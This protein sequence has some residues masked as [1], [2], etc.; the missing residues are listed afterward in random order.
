MRFQSLTEFTRWFPSL[1]WS[2]VVAAA[3]LL[4]LNQIRA[5]EAPDA[6]PATKVIT[7]IVEFW[8]L[9]EADRA[10]SHPFRIECDVTHYDAA[11]KNLW[12]EDATQGGYVSVGNRTLPIK[13]GQ[14]IIV[15]GTF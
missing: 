6:L 9:S 13:S 11:W 5:Q 7:S 1:R 8:G 12:V 2:I 3:S 14:R 10:R 15:T 4:L